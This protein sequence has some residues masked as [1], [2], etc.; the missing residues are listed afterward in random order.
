MAAVNIGPIK[1][2]KSFEILAGDLRERILSGAIQPGE[3]LPNE[4]ELGDQTGLSRG[5][6]REALR[7]LEA[8]GLVSTKA[9]RYGGRVALEPTSDFLSTSIQSFVRGRRVP[10]ASLIETAE[11]LEPVLA[12]LAAQHRTDSDL[13]T[14]RGLGDQ[15]ESSTIAADVHRANAR[16]HMAVAR[17]SHNHLLIG[18]AEALSPLIHD[19]HVE[20]FASPDIRDAVARAHERVYRA[21]LDRDADAARRRMARHIGAYRSRIEAVAPE[22]V[23]IA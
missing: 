19:P 18:V 8:Q 22:T 15:L 13:A 10:F 21:I 14:L 2:E 5:S 23:T 11:A 6:V 20:D 1:V 12:A 16:W 7:I 17:A 3:S 9:G 4:R